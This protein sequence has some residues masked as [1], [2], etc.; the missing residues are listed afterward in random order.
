[1]KGLYVLLILILSTNELLAQEILAEDSVYFNPAIR[2]TPLSVI[3]NNEN[4]HLFFTN[5]AT[6][7]YLKYDNQ[8]E[9]IDKGN[10]SKSNY[11]HSQEHGFIVDENNSIHLFFSRPDYRSFLVLSIKENG[12]DDEQIID[13]DLENEKIID[14]FTLKGDFHVLTY[15][16]KSS[17]VNRY[18]LK[19]SK[20]EKTTYDLYSKGFCEKINGI[21]DLKGVFKKQEIQFIS[22]DVPAVIGQAIKK[23]KI[24]PS[25]E[26][27]EIKISSD[28][29]L[30][31]TVIINLSLDGNS[32]NLQYY[33]NDYNTFKVNTRIKSNSFL[34]NETLFQILASKRKGMI[35]IKDLSNN[36]ILKK[37]EFDRESNI[38]FNN[39]EIYQDKGSFSSNSERVRDT[40]VFLNQMTSGRIGLVANDFNEKIIM[41]F[42]GIST[43]STPV[44]PG[45]GLPIANFG[46]VNL[47]MSA[48]GSVTNSKA[49]YTRSL[50][51]KE[52]FE[53][54][55]GFAGINIFELIHVYKTEE[56]QLKKVIRENIFKY[57]D[58]FIY[59]FFDTKKGTYSLLKF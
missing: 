56:A 35:L 8:F 40:K 14:A 12:E 37:Y 41:I 49:T 43:Y 42:G 39:S 48:F 2:A 29:R 59:G 13:L 51:N 16:K 18:T 11:T 53:Q 50:L 9:L 36:D 17:I 4:I 26:N 31:S 38:Y 6:V 7:S 55:N 30:G 19:E 34:F 22:P 23:L 15:T 5:S 32:F 25:T 33:G 45:I 24:F 52:S 47:F 21:C 58:N 46:P 1:M 57:Q 28:H 54:E 44:G 27:N 3:D 10:Y 20:F